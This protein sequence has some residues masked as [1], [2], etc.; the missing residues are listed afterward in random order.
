MPP[1][2]QHHNHYH[3]HQASLFS[4]S[5]LGW[6]S[7]TFQHISLAG[8]PT[9]LLCLSGISLGNVCVGA[10]LYRL[11]SGQ[12]WA[13]AL[14]KVYGVLF[15]APGIGVM[16][17][18]TVLASLVLNTIFIFGLFVFA[19]FLSMISDEVKQQ[20][21]LGAQQQFGEDHPQQPTHAHTAP[22]MPSCAL[23]P[24]FLL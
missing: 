16:Q 7:W 24:P 12:P 4:F 17:E 1:P 14:F 8:L 22:V 13:R 20:V 19:T 5:W 6:L 11:A 3:H 23:V 21:S 9:R 15:R 10:C 2:Y 18:E